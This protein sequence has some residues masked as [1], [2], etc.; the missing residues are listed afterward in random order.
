MIIEENKYTD[1]LKQYYQ[2]VNCYNAVVE[3]NK[4]LQSELLELKNNKK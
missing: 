4:Q 1:L 2:L 3:Q